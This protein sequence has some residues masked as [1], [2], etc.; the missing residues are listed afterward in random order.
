MSNLGY[1]GKRKGSPLYLYQDNRQ[2]RVPSHPNTPL[3][4][5][6]LWRLSNSMGPWCDWMGAVELHKGW[7]RLLFLSHSLVL[8]SNV[9]D[10]QICAGLAPRQ[11]CLID[12]VPFTPTLAGLLT[13]PASLHLQASDR[14]WQASLRGWPGRRQ[15]QACT[16]LTIQRSLRS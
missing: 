9:F 5:G 15:R 14:E 1:S 8:L 3:L 11:V 7:T 10:V 13:G 2:T 6:L 16:E 12:D 4:L